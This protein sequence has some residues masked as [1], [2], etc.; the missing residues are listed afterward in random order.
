[1]TF[2]SRDLRDQVT[3]ATQASDGDYDVDAIVEA[4]IERHGAVDIDTL[5][6]DEF[7]GIVMDHAI[8]AELWFIDKVADYLGVGESTA[9]GQLSRWGIKAV[10]YQPHPISRRAAARFDAEAVRAAHRNR[11]GQGARTDIT[12]AYDWWIVGPTGVTLPEETGRIRARDDDHALELALT[13]SN[14][15]RDDSGED[16][17]VVRRPARD[18]G[19]GNWIEYEATTLP[20]S[21]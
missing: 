5:D 10:D 19:L 13:A 6:S 4:I 12:H 20:V 16:R 18:T 2:T 9:R 21:A 11:A 1:M 17:L 3:I 8:P 15:H 14:R 7:W